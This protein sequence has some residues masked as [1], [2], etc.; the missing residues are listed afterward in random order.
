MPGR[1][2]SAFPARKRLI[3]VAISACFASAPAWSNPTAPQVV[4]GSASFAQKGNLITVTNSAGAIINWKG[5]SIGANETT[6]F[7]Q[8][9]AAS[10]VL[11][12][13]IANDP[14]VLLGTLSS[15]GKVWLV[16]PSGIMVGQ[17]ARIDVGGFVAST[18]NVRN[19][20]FLAGRLNFQATPNA[21]KVENYGQIT[22]P[23]G[24]SVYLVAP[25]VENH[26][27]I[28][29]PNG[30]V[31]LAAGQKVNLI[32]T[33]T[34]G[35][36]VE[37][38]GSEGSATNLGEILSEAGRIGMAGVLVKNGGSLNVSSVVR[39]GGR[40][41]LKAS[42]R[43]ELDPASR[44]AADGIRGGEILAKVETANELSGVLVGRGSLSAQ[45]DASIG[46]GGF[47]ETSA[48]RLDIDKL[49]VAAGGGT[50]LLDPNNITIQATG[51]DTN[52]S[53]NPDFFTIGDNAL[54][55]TGTIQTA[56]N[57]GTNVS[58]TTGVATPNGEAGNIFVNSA[59]TKSSGA[60]S[61]LTL[62]AH[63]N[64]NVYAAITSSSPSFPLNLTMIADSD[65]NTS[66]QINIA[67]N[68]DLKGGLL[69]TN[70]A[71]SG[72]VA[73]SS[74]TVAL[75]QA[76]TFS[77]LLWTGGTLAGTGLLRVYNLD[78]QAGTLLGSLELPIE[79][80]GTLSTSGI[81]A[82]GNTSG[83]SG[84]FTNI[85]GSIT[86][87]TP[88]GSSALSLYN[89]TFNNHGN[90]SFTTDANISDW[91][92]LGVVN[93]SGYLYK[94][95][96]TVATST[97]SPKFVNTG[98]VY[99]N[100]GSLK[101]S[102]PSASAATHTGSFSVYTGSTLDF[103]NGTQTLDATSTVYGPGKLQVSGGTVNV[104][105]TLGTTLNLG[106][107]GGTTNIN[108]NTT[109]LSLNFTG[110]T[111]GGTGTLSTYSLDW[112]AG[113]LLGSL[114][115]LA[116]DPFLDCVCP[117]TGTLS[118]AGSKS[119]GNTSGTA[120]TF[121]NA[122]T[123]TDSTTAG[124]S[125]LYLY[126]GTFNNQ[127]SFEF[128]TDANISD[129]NGLGAVN[130]TGTLTKITGTGTSKI[131]AKFVNSFGT[132]NADS[133]TL[134]LSP[135]STSSATHT[136]TF[137]VNSGAT[138]QFAGG[139]HTLDTDSTVNGPEAGVGT[140]AVSGG[141]VDVNGTLGSTLGL[142]ISGGTANFN[143]TTTQP[144][145]SFTGGTLGGTGTLST[146]SLSW[147]TGTVLGSLTL[148]SA[149][150]G[151][152]STTG[153]KTIGNTSGTA[154]TFTNAGT[155]TDSTNNSYSSLYL[156]NGTFNNQGSF[157]FTTDANIGD[158]NGLGVVSNSGT[159]TKNIGTGTSSIEPKFVNTGGL[160]NANSG[161]LN[162]SPP[163]TS[164]A[165]HTG[166][167]NTASGV[168]LQFSD[169]T[170]TL[171]TASAVNGPGKLQVSGGTVNIGGTLGGTL[172]L[173]LSGGTVNFNV[174]T[175]QPSLS[176]TGG[177]LGGTG[178]LST[179]SLS[180]SAGTVL[181]SLTL[182]SGGS[183][184]LSTTGSKYIG[185]TSGT[186][187]TFTNA[188]TIT[189]STNNAYSS[190]YLYNGTFN[191][192]G[193][194][195][196]TTDAN[197]SD[198]NGLGV[199]NN[200]GS[201]T[202]NTGTGTSTIEAKFVNTSGIVNANSGTL[203]L[204]PPSTSSATHTGTFN[205]ASGVTLQF[206]DGT[207][208]LDTASAVNGPGK[209][210][211]SGGTVNI[212]GTLG[213]T[214][215]LGLSGGTANFNVTATQPSLSFTGG[216][217]GG[218]GTLST[219]SLSWSAG[220]VLGSLT[221]ASGA[222]GTLSTTGSKYI[223][224]TSGTAGTFTNAGTI[225]DS[226][227]NGYSALYLYNGTFNNQGSY[228][229]TTDAYLSDWSG[230]GV[231][232]NTGTLTK[233]GGT[234]TSTINPKFVNTGDGTTTGI[235]NVNSGT[236]QLSP[237]SASSATQTG[238]FNVVSGSVFHFA[239]GTHTLNNN[240][241]GSGNVNLTGGTLV[242]SATTTVPVF[243]L[244]GGTISGTGV[245]TVNNLS[246]TAGTLLGSLK[247]A[248]GGS[249]TLSTTGGKYIGNTSGTAGTFTN[250][251]TLTDSTN[252]G[253]SAL[254]LHNGT[255]NNQGSYSFTTDSNFYD[256]NG[257]GL[258]NN[259]G[260]LTKSGGTGTSTINPKFVNTGDGSATG[261]VNVSSGTLQLSPASASSATQTGV[262]NV[263]AGATLQFAS[264][265]HTLN[266]SF[267]GSGSVNLSGATLIPAATTTI[268]VFSF[269]GGTI[270]GSGVLTTNSL[271]WSAGT[272][273][274]SLT[275]A[276]GGSGTL[277]TSGGKYIG[278]S[279]GTA[280]TFTNAGS[281]TDNTPNGYSALYLY[282]GAF[283]NQGSLT[284]STDTYLNDYAGLGVVNNT[285][286]LTKS[287]GAGTSTIHAKFVNT[288]DGSAGGIVNVNSGTLQL[289]PPS[290][291]STTLTGKFNVSTGAALQ[292]ASGTHTLDNS[293]TG[294]GNVNLTGGTLV[295]S[296]TTTVPVFNYS[297][298]IISGTGVLTADKLSWSAGTLLGGLKL[299]SGGSGTLSTSGG[300]YIGNSSGT[301]G[302][303][304]NAGTLTDNTPNG[305]SGLYLYNGAFNNQG[306]FTLSTDANLSDWNSL[307]A[308]NNSGTFAKDGG[309]GS[310]TIYP[311]FVNTGDGSSTGIVNA[312][313]GT[314]NLSPPGSSS[315][316]HTGTFSVASGAT[317]QFSNGTHTLNNSFSGSGTVK[318]AGATLVPSSST[319]VPVL[320]FT[321]GN[322]SGSGVLTAN[323]LTW[324]GG[325]VLGSLV[326]AS[327]GTGSLSASGGKYIGNSGGIGATFTNAGT[328]T[329][330][331]PTGYTGLY[332]YSGTFNNQGTYTFGTDAHI[333]DWGGMGLVNNTGTLTKSGGTGTSSIHPKFTNTGA[334]NINSG[335]LNPTF[336]SNTNS[337]A[338]A[339]AS[340]ATLSTG[341]LTNA[342]T[343]SISGGGTVNL[344]TATLT[345]NGT[346][347][348]GTSTAAGTLSLTG[349]LSMGSS[350]LLKVK[351]GGATAGTYD[352]LAVTGNVV[353]GGT[354]NVS[355]IDSYV[356]VSGD[357]HS[358][359]G[360]TG[361]AT[362]TFATTS[363]P[364]NIDLGYNLYS[365][366]AART[367]YV[368]SST[369]KFFNNSANN[370]DWGTAA[371][372]TGGL[373]AS[374]DEALIDTNFAVTH[375]YGIDTVGALSITNG[376]SLDVSGGSLTVGGATSLGGTLTV[377]GSG[378]TQLNGSLSGTGTTAVQ[379]GTLT[380][381][382]P[383]SGIANLSLSGGTLNG[384]GNLT[385]SNSFTR[386]G[387]TIGST[388]SG[389]SITQANGN[390]APGAL[391][392]NGPV[393]LAAST[394][395]LTLDSVS[396]S[397]IVA[398]AAGGNLT[399][400]SGA[401]IT[402]SGSG[403]ALELA[404]SGSFI[405]NAG[406]SALSASSGRWLVYSTDPATDVRGGLSYGFKHYGLAYSG[407]TYTG[408]GSGN[409]F[410]YS[411]LPSVTPKLT[412]IVSK[413][414]D[415]TTTA[416]LVSGNFTAVGAIDDDS[417]L[418][419]N[420]T[421]G[422]YADRH[423]GSGKSVSAT[424]ALT[425]A[426][427][428]A[429]SV[430][431]YQL[432]STTASGNIGS[433]TPAALTVSATG[434][435]R[436]YDGT[437]SASVSLADDRFS[438]DTLTLSYGSAA[439][440]DRNVGSGKAVT[441]SGISL[442]GTDA[443][444]YTVA[445]AGG[446]TTADITVRPLS[447]WTGSVSSLWSN[448]ANWD[449][450]P[451]SAN[452][453]AVAI[454]AGSG[455]VTYDASAGSTTLQNV[456]SAQTLALTGGSLT[457]GGAL[458]TVGYVQS[459]GALAGNGNLNVSNSFSQTGGTIV[460]GGTA[461][462]AIMQ[463]S[464]NLSVGSLSA[465]AVA[466]AAPNGAIA[467][468]AP[469]VAS[470]LVTNSLAGTSLTDAGNNIGSFSAT[471]SGSGNVV[472]TNNAPLTIAGISNSNG[473]IT[474]DNTGAV[475][476]T[477]PISAP[478]GS[479]SVQAHSPLTIGAGG[480][481]AGGS[482]SLIAGATSNPNDL[483][484]I[485]GPV[486][487]TAST[488]SVAFSA[489]DGIAQ[490]ANVST[491]GCGVTATAQAGD[492]VMSP[493]A[494]TSSGGG[495]IAYTATSGNIVLTSLNAGSGAISLIAGGN[496]N[497]A[498]NF[499][500]TNLIGESA[501]IVARGNAFLST[502]V[503]TLDE[504]VEGD[505]AIK[506]VITGKVNTGDVPEILPEST[507]PAVNEVVSTIVTTSQQQT[508]QETQQTPPP[509][510]PLPPTTAG[511]GPLA[512]VTGN[513]TIGGTEGTFG[514]G[515]TPSTPAAGE[516]EKPP[517]DK[518]A[519]AKSTES[520]SA[521]TKKDEAKKDEDKKDDEKKK[522]ERESTAKK[523]EKK[524][525]AKKAPVCN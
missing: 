398:N 252:A 63:N 256:W 56:L 156:Y 521:E 2:T 108:V 103:N 39:E 118:T 253:Y 381:N 207:H 77:S 148:A 430:Y 102:A 357:A 346:L 512:L 505:Y 278:S 24:G 338:I 263:A 41:F 418:L 31:I 241:A 496:I 497:A 195:T 321:A 163:S 448:P 311:K 378:S 298:G 8:P 223:G 435:N 168:T 372:W 246:W 32:D 97:I 300:K 221:L 180:W 277:S 250:A 322:V 20:D 325:T 301:A 491:G 206:S 419:D 79:S 475:T 365:G 100:A 170:H 231:V 474:V 360:M 362:G 80:T 379:G 218:T 192:Q 4:S 511:A 264:G 458:N 132:V 229:F 71:G 442:T 190:L 155:I 18:L 273:L 314:L 88:G 68:I 6:R 127:G 161:T 484:V 220:T 158:W 60:A 507:A 210:Q 409:G 48:A 426:A 438:G 297:G 450:L 303:F 503:S 255:F 174:T 522:K 142:G 29:A 62:S 313:S 248:S 344:G 454:P 366:E 96:G 228:T 318:L 308:I 434:V 363:F 239:S 392:V 110:G 429:A 11:N 145:L 139:T 26:G 199:V 339:V 184:T 36:K 425:S 333:G 517:A 52:V 259:T 262:F 500:G 514:G 499:E 305:Y 347:A 294:S 35:V 310:S 368:A 380:I 306:S 21:G 30:E 349:N 257:L 358:F 394:G 150:S 200:S 81:K 342:S 510:A 407:T 82:I 471:N 488:G 111:L 361:T 345:N 99:V 384:N 247:L 28:N 157:T 459:G 276:S 295:P 201:L 424:V 69:T 245:L 70:S 146:N 402:V 376:N 469:I 95:A 122:G 290:A 428:G 270:S 135:P 94:N 173:G 417:I 336:A 114:K 460:L 453:L 84:T 185:N 288:G 320:N 12:R 171:D 506:D 370:L 10:S 105:G 44:I 328:L 393:S 508:A 403:D 431:G 439:F 293:F 40:I 230:L 317:L 125:A 399:L 177:T 524:T 213:G 237:P 159:L 215:N 509:P 326:L 34:P 272:L 408:P 3:V 183:G 219:N 128:T 151:T 137:A 42:Q 411:I 516:G 406:A 269:S 233:S 457:I 13:V 73:L 479:V 287:T 452:V 5:F 254:Y 188:G 123:L 212:G 61:T 492:I 140:L 289:S 120:G 316:T 292:F 205:A 274:G 193:S 91:N 501:L 443:G 353:M 51:S 422:T 232:N 423:A 22:T 37:V 383:I 115:L 197:I 476:T 189:D 468:S 405:N 352:K 400:N 129:W 186:A 307:G 375:A 86:D 377:S 104:G 169:G 397:K 72:K 465:P 211:V 498:S 446:S 119:I 388:F 330:N 281:L 152:L 285:G 331:T 182:A 502:Q 386:T 354:L 203:N 332:F 520:K 134:N 234:G 483:L 493:G 162:L 116:Y 401:T 176:F 369:S 412:G 449:A 136:G 112:T 54:I 57:A 93:N 364:S 396:G 121:T 179:N 427:N 395:A 164:S 90:F 348:P 309:T 209:L 371:N 160:V 367:V 27:L 523:E 486:S 437:T 92:G 323:S 340:G 283:N 74:G 89:G 389:L 447:T 154:G 282:S 359:L 144:S 113:T 467:Q 284:L 14:S 43:I 436:T 130:N 477:G 9:S 464:G 355:L 117:G 356:P 138:L 249:G 351:L 515:P 235:V 286:T 222:S 224:N 78:W 53:G 382:G 478:N 196:F 280:G 216:T 214:L 101:I 462:A 59:I 302:T 279:S 456:N 33:G 64:V 106:L 455:Q 410:I 525:T 76:T 204:S 466:L 334:I 275:L 335:T 480:V 445:S 518:I 126:N 487:T 463:A 490:N 19:E 17:G 175:T 433:I 258:V 165:T 227:N 413:T 260:T 315:V 513:Q 350:S 149:G 25:A 489:A 473:N 45:G 66:G 194:F 261:I 191:N 7:N 291:T 472:L 304:T 141:T 504:R 481:S 187:G 432:A 416:T 75:D 495:A 391:T 414:Y 58:I 329:D 202:K 327:G 107:S 265:T 374:S 451:D 167:F 49:T 98:N 240:F 494:T 482:I 373:P 415:G 46:S 271:S 440:A 133:G 387:G 124:Y 147:S 65:N 23:S 208:T 444:N 519:T 420:P 441:V 50:W 470:S 337:G 461:T 1:N 485:S 299:A 243:N 404:A 226:T 47:I 236:L 266:N 324:S 131:G 225:T 242:P 217:I 83:A 267:T 55:T 421:T 109:A 15:N 251:G 341:A 178:T 166:T 87:S 390:L 385:V 38:A 244:S 319:S 181:G 16:N 85:G 238:T 153:S 268:P 296:A 343:G 172:N 312:Y 67:S 198:W 143:V